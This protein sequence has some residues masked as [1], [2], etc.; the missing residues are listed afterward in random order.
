[1]S[2][3][4]R[5]YSKYIPM[6]SRREKQT[7]VSGETTRRVVVE[8]KNGRTTTHTETTRR[9][10][11]QQNL[12]RN[13]E[14]HS[15]R[16]VTSSSRGQD[17]VKVY[18]TSEFNQRP[19]TID[20][21][22]FDQRISSS[23]IQTQRPYS[24]LSSDSSQIKFDSGR[25]SPKEGRMKVPTTTTKKSPQLK[26]SMLKPQMQG[27]NVRSA[28]HDRK[29]PTSDSKKPTKQSFE[30][31]KNEILS[32]HNEYR[33]RHPGTPLL[34]WND[35]LA[36][37]AQAWCNK[38]AGDD[39]MMHQPASARAGQGENLAGAWGQPMTGKKA[40]DDWY[41]EINNYN[42]ADP[43][44]SKT[45]VGHFTQ[46]VWKGSRQIG[47]AMATSA[48]GWHFVVARYRPGGNMRGAEKSNVLPL[49]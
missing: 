3:V 27:D 16:T 48:T 44:M 33:K 32:T 46:V 10:T 4:R 9:T 20:L 19:L 36:T 6:N 35:D 39:R 31:F 41:N 49:N 18:S 29:N 15:Q 26:P 14:T 8:T 23:N 47:A 11:S 12:S 25:S 2:I 43:K 1:M 30:E 45:P 13:P 24:M 42:F 37:K 28:P 5:L 7:I 21:S 17:P 22:D 38:M 34:V 40:T